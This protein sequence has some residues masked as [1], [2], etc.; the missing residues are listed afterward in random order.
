MTRI[1]I[2]QTNPRLGDVAF[3]LSAM[4]ARLEASAADLVLFPECALTG[5]GFATRE[6][7]WRH[8]EPIPGRSVERMTEALRR[9]RSQYAAFGM[10]ERRGDDMFN[11]AALIGRDGV[12]GTYRK[13]HLLHLG[14]DRFN[15]PG[16]LGFPVFDLPIGR[17][18]LQ[19]CFDFSF[20]EPTRCQK[21]AGAQLIAV[22]TNWPAQ[23]EVSCDFTP[24]VRSQENHICVATCDR[25]GSESGFTFRGRSRLI[26]CDSRVVAEASPTEEQSLVGDLDLQAADRNRV[27]YVAGEYELDRIAA[28]RPEH[29][30]GL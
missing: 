30:H 13:M 8:A 24:R 10:L 21:L 9:S 6:E 12:V 7:A 4:T 14:V 25:V 22:I 15:R 23:A 3:N 28:R 5:Y 20:P 29:Y 1:A 27:V 18:G 26:D 19:I 17:I 16:D 2:E 11:A